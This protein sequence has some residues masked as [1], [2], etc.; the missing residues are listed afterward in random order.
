MLSELIKGFFD[1]FMIS[2]TKLG[3]TFLGKHNF[4][5]FKSTMFRQ[6]ST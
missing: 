5:H 6:Y 3:D 4:R 1:V 2:E